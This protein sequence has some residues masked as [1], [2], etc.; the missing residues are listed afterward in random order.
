M[1]HDAYMDVKY[2][3]NRGY[4]KKYALEFVANHYRLTAGERHLLARCV[5]PDAWI[6]K[7][8]KKLLEPG[9]LRGRVL[10]V[11]GFNVLITLESLLDGEAIL[12]EDGLVR[13]LKYLGRYRLKER[14]GDLLKEMALSLTDVGPEK[15]VFFY[16]KNVP[17]SG[18][19]K[20]LT[21][22]A[23]G[24]RVPCEVALVRSPDFELKTYDT[25]ATA[26]AGII[27]KVPHVFDL[28][29]YTALRLGIKARPFSDFLFPENFSSV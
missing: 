11:D 25:V 7:V 3:L 23:L 17:K 29:A 10:A 28:A 12:C 13:D 4:R 26:D 2:L 27:Q 6:E 21:E 18:I 20:K 8:R 5:F 16:G 19:V 1:L 24:S 15:V 9:D 14:T 22:K